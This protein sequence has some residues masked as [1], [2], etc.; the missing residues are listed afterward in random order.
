MVV[1]PLAEGADRLVA[2]AVL[3]WP[4]RGG[5]SPPRLEAVLPLP[6]DVYVQDFATAESRAEFWALRA[7]ATAVHTL[8]PVPTREGAYDQAGRWVVDNCDVLIAIWGGR[9][10]AGQGGTAEIVD[11]ARKSGRATYWIHADTGAVTELFPATDGSP[12]V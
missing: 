6:A 2:K 8:A 10:A 12:A 3:A 9:P 7:Q 11:C 5:S 4:T 1:S